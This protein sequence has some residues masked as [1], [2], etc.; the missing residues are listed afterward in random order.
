MIDM[1]HFFRYKNSDYGQHYHQATGN[2][3]QVVK[4]RYGSRAADTGKVEE[5]VYT[6]GPR[7]YVCNKK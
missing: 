3:R 4:G 5:T 6:A 2:A 1:I 7:G